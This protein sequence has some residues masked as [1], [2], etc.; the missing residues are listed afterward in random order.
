[1]GPEQEEIMAHMMSWGGVEPRRMFG[2]DAFLVKGKLF[3]FFD[4]KGV[5]VK[6]PPPLREELLREPWVAP[7]THRGKPFGTWLRL[8]LRGPQDMA[9]ALAAVRESYRYVREA[10]G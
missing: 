6:V 10:R 1:V 4:R 7:L 8:C 9:T 3:A 2:C 5:A